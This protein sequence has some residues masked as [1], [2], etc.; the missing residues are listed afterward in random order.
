MIP[1][2]QTSTPADGLLRGMRHCLPALM[3]WHRPSRGRS[4]LVHLAFPAKRG[5]SNQFAQDRTWSQY[6]PHSRVER[7]RSRAKPVL[8]GNHH[9]TNVLRLPAHSLRFRSPHLARPKFNS[10]CM[11][12][13]D[14]EHYGVDL[15]SVCMRN[16]TAIPQPD[17][18]ADP[19]NS[20]ALVFLRSARSAT[21]SMHDTMPDDLIAFLV[22][23]IR[24][25]AGGAATVPATF[26]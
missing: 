5:N 4:R 7:R 10:K 19:M 20:T 17:A 8:C 25:S 12:A 18:S 26:L 21:Q 9:H 11:V 2:A 14:T 16:K 15:Y 13:P 22:A 6:S 24:A 3:V 1:P 23:G